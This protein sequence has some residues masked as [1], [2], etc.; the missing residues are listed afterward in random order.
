MKV[1]FKKSFSKAGSSFD[2]NDHYGQRIKLLMANSESTDFMEKDIF[3]YFKQNEQKL[4]QELVVANTEAANLDVTVRPVPAGAE[5]FG[6]QELH[7]NY[8]FDVTVES[9]IYSCIQ[10]LP[11]DEYQLIEP[12]T[13]KVFKVQA[14][15]D[16]TAYVVE[17]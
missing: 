13:G 16:I 3:A 1:K 17:E 8:K 6:Q 14:I 5:W 2:N 7:F 12:T 4:S 10:V 9:I 15:G 11:A